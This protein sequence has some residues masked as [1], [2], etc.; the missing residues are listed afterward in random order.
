MKTKKGIKSTFTDHYS[1][2]IELRGIPKK[3]TKEKQQP[4][5]NLNKEGGWIAY[6]SVTNKEAH[7]IEEAVDKEADIDE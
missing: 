3:Q 4:T 5:W 1:L 6:E 7:K 2:K